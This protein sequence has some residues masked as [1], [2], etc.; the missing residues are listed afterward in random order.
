M[1]L[2]LIILGLS[3]LL[4]GTQLVTGRPDKAKVKWGDW[5]DW[6]DWGDYSTSS[7]Y[8]YDYSSSWSPYDTTTSSDWSSTQSNE[9]DGHDCLYKVARD[10]VDYD[11]KDNK[12]L[13]ESCGKKKK[14]SPRIIGGDDV[15]RNEWPWLVALGSYRRKQFSHFCGGT[16]L[17]KDWVL[18]AAHCVAEYENQCI[19]IKRFAVKVGEH[20]LGEDTNEEEVIP[21]KKIIIHKDYDHNADIPRNDIA[22]VQL[23]KSA[24]TDIDEIGSACLPS[25]K[26]QKYMKK[27]CYVIGWGSTE[28]DEYPQIAKDVKVK[29]VNF[30][31]CNK[32]YKKK[33]DDGMLCAGVIGSG[34][35]SCQGDS[36]GPLV[37][38]MKKTW[39]LVGVVS[40]GYG[41]AQKHSGV[42]TDVYDYKDWIQSVISQEQ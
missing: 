29:I 22:L 12:P 20:H 15:E 37:C 1:N 11:L 13:D 3:C 28:N 39:S 40:W 27:N 30:D 25:K 26:H 19:D 34:R 8:D 32:K 24:N 4:S 33:L 2:R 5:F 41:C 6:F 17:N 31:K 42:Y 16:L 7:W 18:T 35:D 21:V 9:A 36:G 38:N 14:K 10:A 23:S